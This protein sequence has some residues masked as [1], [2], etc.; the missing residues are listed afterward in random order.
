MALNLKDAIE[1]AIADNANELAAADS[2]GAIEQLAPKIAQEA[3]AQYDA[4]KDKFSYR[5]VIVILGLVA[6]GVA[7]TYALHTL[8]PT[9]KPLRDLPDALI[10]LGSAAVGALTGLLA[11]APRNA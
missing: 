1:R 11:P 2:A 10:A 8:T 6:L 7:F 4:T 5:A 9:T 3:E